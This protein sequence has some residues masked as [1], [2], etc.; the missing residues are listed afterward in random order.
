MAS[1]GTATGSNSATVMVYQDLA[2]T[3]TLSPS[4]LSSGTELMVNFQITGG[5][6]PY[7]LQWQGLPSPCSGNAP[8]SVSTS[9]SSGFQ[10]NPS[11]TGSTQVGLQVTDNGAPNHSVAS[12]MQSLQVTSSNNNNN[13]GNGSNNKGGNGSGNSSSILSNLGSFLS[14]LLIGAV[15]VFVLL[16]ITAVSTLATAILVARRLPPRTSGGGS[17]ATQPCPSCGK[18]VPVGSKFCLECGKPM[19]AD[20]SAPP[21]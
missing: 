8:N 19:S 17:A 12:T 1:N 18:P 6:S 5:Q 9:G 14:Y 16:I 7:Q 13:N 2:V 20:K 4:S 15:I 11:Q 3:L 21:G 10:C